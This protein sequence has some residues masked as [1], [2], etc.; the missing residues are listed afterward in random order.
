MCCTA[1]KCWTQWSAVS[2]NVRPTWSP[3]S[4]LS[5]PTPPIHPHQATTWKQNTYKNTPRHKT[6]INHGAIIQQNDRW[7]LQPDPL[8]TNSPTNEQ[9]VHLRKFDAASI[10]AAHHVIQL[11]ATLPLSLWQCLCNKTPTICFPQRSVNLMLKK[12]SVNRNLY[13]DL[14]CAAKCTPALTLT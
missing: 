12:K 10:S 14:W 2:V 7:K 5:P 3:P 4:Y 8:D 13:L 11:F 6:P 9:T 1:K